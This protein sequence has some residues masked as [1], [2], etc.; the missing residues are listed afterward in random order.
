MGQDPLGFGKATELVENTGWVK[1]GMFVGI[2]DNSGMAR[3]GY[4]RAATTATQP[5]SPPIARFFAVVSTNVILRR[6]SRIELKA[7]G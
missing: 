3:G 2:V 5:L 7:A 4:D 1:E 6:R